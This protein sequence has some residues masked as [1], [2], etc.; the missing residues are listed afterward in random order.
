MTTIAQRISKQTTMRVQTGLGV[1]GAATG[2]VLRRTSSVFTADRDMFPSNELTSHFQSTG[3]SYGLK[4]TGGS[5]AG[6]LSAGTYKIPIAALLGKA[7]VAIGAY[8]AGTDVTVTGTGTV[9]TDASG[10]YFAAG[11]K[12][13]M[14]GRWTGFSPTTNNS[15]N[16]WITALTD[17]VMTGI[18]LDGAAGVDDTSGDTVTFTPVGKSC[19]PHMSVHTKDYLQ[20][21]EWYSDL[22]D[23]DLFT[24]L[25]CAGIDFDLPATGNATFSSSYVGLTRV[26]SGAQVMTA[27]TAETTTGIMSAI[28]GRIFVNGTSTPITS[29][30]ITASN[31]AAVLP[32]EVGSNSSSDVSRSNKVVSGSFTSLLRDQVLS[33]LYDAETAIGLIAVLTADQTATSDFMGFSLGKIKI[34]SDAPDDAEGIMRTYAFIAE[35]NAAGADSGANDKT[36]M[37]V[38]D[39]AA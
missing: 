4:K 32:A 36:I 27:P 3:A 33:A 6:E 29:L 8:A 7:F 35:L 16:F 26:L 11:L 14:V 5:I 34:T 37:T 15:R 31:S 9:F 2:Q 1:V 39:S 12:V 17:S 22:T 20:V 13:G 38:F 28:N 21:E 30:K 10:G 18:F 19:L 24:D 23:S 25:V